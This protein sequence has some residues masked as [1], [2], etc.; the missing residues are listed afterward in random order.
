[1]DDGETMAYKD[2]ENGNNFLYWGFTYQRRSDVLYT[3]TSKQVGG[4]RFKNKN[5]FGYIQKKLTKLIII[6]KF[7]LWEIYKKKYKNLNKN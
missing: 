2:S 3:L 7:N 4:R 1:L 6:K 5:K